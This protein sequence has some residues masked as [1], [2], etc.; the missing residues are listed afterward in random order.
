MATLRDD[1]YIPQLFGL[2]THKTHT[3][4]LE[5]L[6]KIPLIGDKATPLTDR[7][8]SCCK[9]SHFKLSILATNQQ[10]NTEHVMQVVEAEAQ[11]ALLKVWKANLTGARD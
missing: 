5:G 3:Q 7:S 9:H 2:K 10:L 4:D 8:D 11:M 6:G 1:I